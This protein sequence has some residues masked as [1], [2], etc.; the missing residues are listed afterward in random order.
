MA[1]AGAVVVSKAK[2]DAFTNPA[3]A[4]ILRTAGIHHLVVLGVGVLFE[5]AD[6]A[7]DLVVLGDRR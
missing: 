6:V 4:E 1:P 2:P 5:R 7:A 3:L